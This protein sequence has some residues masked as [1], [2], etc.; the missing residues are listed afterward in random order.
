ME[1][2]KGN[3]NWIITDRIVMSVLQELLQES[4]DK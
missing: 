2:D 1:E 3:V 4:E